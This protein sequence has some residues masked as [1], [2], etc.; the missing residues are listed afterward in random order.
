LQDCKDYAYLFK[1]Y[2]SFSGEVIRK[3][4]DYATK[5][6]LSDD[7]KIGF[8]F[9]FNACEILCSENSF[10]LDRLLEVIKV[11]LDEGSHSDSDSNSND[12]EQEGGSDNLRKHSGESAGE[13]KEED[14][15]SRKCSNVEFIDT[16]KPTIDTADN[17]NVN[18]V[19]PI[20]KAPD[21][22]IEVEENM[23]ASTHES[24]ENE[25]KIVTNENCTEIPNTSG[26]TT[27]TVANPNTFTHHQKNHALMHDLISDDNE[28]ENEKLFN[29]S[30]DQASSSKE[31]Q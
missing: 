18:E 27:T 4:I 21:T 1:Y 5:M 9:P 2:F 17:V 16:H 7:I 12:D 15:S 31:S 8:K 29:I 10:I 19:L 13:S 22:H 6:P 26:T 20:D 3:L 23:S 28:D 14:S 25:E 30:Q 24:K 11:E